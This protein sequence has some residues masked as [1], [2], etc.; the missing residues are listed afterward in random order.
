MFFPEGTF[1]TINTMRGIVGRGVTVTVHENDTACTI[2]SLDPVTNESTDV[3]CSGCDGLYWIPVYSDYTIS[4]HV[5][6]DF[7]DQ[8]NWEPGGIVPEGDCKVTIKYS[9]ENLRRVINS[10]SWLV[11]NIPLYITNYR[12]KGIRGPNEEHEPSRIS[13]ILK[14]ESEN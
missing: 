5:R 2:C 7:A 3:M 14:Q 4:G 13:I 11:D 12:L 6:W 1:D 9:T 8:V 10:Y